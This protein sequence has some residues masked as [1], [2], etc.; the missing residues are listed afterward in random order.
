MQSKTLNYLMI[1]FGIFLILAYSQIY[2]KLPDTTSNEARAT[3]GIY[4]IGVMS[5][6]MGITLMMCTDQQN[7]TDMFIVYMMMMLGVV[8]TVLGG[9]VVSKIQEGAAKAWAVLVMVTGI[10]F[11][12]GGSYAIYSKHGDKIAKLM[13]PKFA[14][15]CGMY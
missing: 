1:L 3:E 11:I 6:T 7:I 9:I 4:T 8:L 15:G 12:V 5:L 2:S 13:A 14:Y 10:L